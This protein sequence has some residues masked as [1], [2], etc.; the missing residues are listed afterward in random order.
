MVVECEMFVLI[1]Y[2]MVYDNFDD[3]ID[4]YNVVL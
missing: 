4:V 1:L 2:V 3:V